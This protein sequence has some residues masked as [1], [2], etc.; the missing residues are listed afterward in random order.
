MMLHPGHLPSPEHLW[1]AWSREPLV[2]LGLGGAALA[3]AAGL[4]R[5]WRRAGR[6]RG[7][8]RRE[9][10]AFAGG[11]LALGAALVSPVDALGGAL[12]SAHMLQHL[13]LVLVAAPLLVLGRT[14]RALLWSLP[15]GGR[16]RLGRWWLG[17]PRVRAAWRALAHPLT[18]WLLHA[19]ALWLWH[20]AV[21]YEAALRNDL[22]HGLE[23]ASFLG[24][25]LLFWWVAIPRDRRP[26]G[27]P[28]GIALLFTTMMHSGVLGALITFA[29][30][31]WYPAH[32]EGARLWGLTLL[33][34]QQLAGLVMWV[35]AG[36]V[37]VLGAAG[38]LYAW[39][40]RGER[41]RPAFATLA[42]LACAG[43]LA[44]CGEAR[45]DHST[46]RVVVAGG[47]PAAG[48]TALQGFGCV[49]CH[50]IPGVPGVR[51][52][53]GPPLDRFA[54]RRYIGGTLPNEPEH[55]IRWI[56]DPQAVN[57]NTAMP[58]LGVVAAVAR[59]MAAYLYTL[60]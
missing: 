26:A 40:E 60:R 8:R 19:A 6:G 35:P 53:V 49:A 23:H 38:L 36:I 13:L 57:P 11:M 56:R 28:V 46:A 10:A 2:L 44:G 22:I 45:R 50:E 21:L 9:A 18:V 1:T 43:L 3:Y 30:T 15:A 48:R 51:G 24:T 25:A 14:E 12:F 52:S 42:T 37:Y 27:Y 39:L 47:D 4:A 58:N 33:E 7:I 41:L 34:D 59:D 31:P 32:A 5:L 55:L 54:A 29:E 20:A 17:A 16:R